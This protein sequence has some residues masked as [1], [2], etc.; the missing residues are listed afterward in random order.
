LHKHAATLSDQIQ[1]KQYRPDLQ[2]NRNTVSAAEKD[3]R[4]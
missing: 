4:K 1:L 3:L 2:A